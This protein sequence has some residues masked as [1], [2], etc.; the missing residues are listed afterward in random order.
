MR[1]QL[2]C[3]V[4][5]FLAY[6]GV[7]SD[8]D[9]EMKALEVDLLKSLYT[10]KVNKQRFPHW[11]VALLNMCR[12]LN[13]LNSGGEDAWSNDE[14]GII[15]REHFSTLPDSFS[16]GALE[17]AYQLIKICNSRTLQPMEK[18]QDRDQDHSNYKNE[19]ILKRKSPYLLKR[20]LHINKPRRPY[21]LK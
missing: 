15:S 21:I 2:I 14:E 4:M 20:Q 8:L 13:N 6:D 1:T 12:L 3:L 10:S 16:L 7:C 9:Q 5:L 18:T 19:E 17:A 11:K